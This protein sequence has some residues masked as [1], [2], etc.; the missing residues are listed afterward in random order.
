MDLKRFVKRKVTVEQ[1]RFLRVEEIGLLETPVSV[2]TPRY[3][4]KLPQSYPRTKTYPGIGSR[5]PKNGLHRWNS[6]D[7]R[8]K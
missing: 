8:I 5:L 2:F 1:L 6:T 4:K 3:P 7:K